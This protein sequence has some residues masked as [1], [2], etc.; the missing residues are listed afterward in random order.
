MPVGSTKRNYGLYSYGTEIQVTTHL[1]SDAHSR[2]FHDRF[3]DHAMRIMAKYDFKIVATWESKKDNRTEFVYLL[4]WPDKETM[5]DRWRKFLQ[6]QEWIK[7]KK[8]TGEMNGPLVGEIQDRTLYL[9][10]YSPREV[11]AK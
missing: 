8:E 1:D 5:T 4:E 6:D 2:R 3:R 9:T 10:D 7:I 11:L